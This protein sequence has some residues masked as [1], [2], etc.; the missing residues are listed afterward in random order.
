[1]INQNAQQDK[2]SKRIDKGLFKKKKPIPLLERDWRELNLAEQFEYMRLKRKEKE[3]GNN[4][5]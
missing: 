2:A 5:L 1:M 3:K 4:K